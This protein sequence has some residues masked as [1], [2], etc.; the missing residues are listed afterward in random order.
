MPLK[1][2]LADASSFSAKQLVRTLPESFSR[3]VQTVHN[4]HDMCQSLLTSQFDV[5][6][7]DTGFESL[8]TT[9][10]IDHLRKEQS[11]IQIIAVT[12][13]MQSENKEMLIAS[14]VEYILQKPVSAA[15][16]ES[17]LSVLSESKQKKDTPPSVD[18]LISAL[19]AREV[20]IEAV[21]LA[22]AEICDKNHV[23]DNFVLAGFTSQVNVIRTS[24]LTMTV[25]H[26]L[27][28]ASYR[29]FVTELGAEGISA[30]CLLLLP[31]CTADQYQ[32]WLNVGDSV[33]I[34]DQESARDFA[35]LMTSRIVSAFG[36]QMGLNFT[37]QCPQRLDEVFEMSTNDLVKLEKCFEHKVAIEFHFWIESK[38]SEVSVLLIFTDDSIPLV[39]NK[40]AYLSEEE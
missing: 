9:D 5:L 24:E 13:D 6:I 1:I 40:L 22:I 34:N 17:T 14:G 10:A 35:L 27:K 25:F 20:Y 18:V 7:F 16:L 3:H 19:G 30:E 26:R 2:L 8:D 28:E 37:L 32:G 33:E 29:T 15:Q 38:A 4:A 31:K 21:R 39:N 11:E 12:V 23:N 36:Q